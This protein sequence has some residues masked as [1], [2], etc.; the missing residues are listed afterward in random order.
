MY[1]SDEYMT[2]SCKTFYV[3]VGSKAIMWSVTFAKICGL[4]Q[5]ESMPLKYITYR[6]NTDSHWLI[7]YSDINRDVG[8]CL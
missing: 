8:V 5:L 2:E 4:C 1:T 6:Y 7:F 3:F